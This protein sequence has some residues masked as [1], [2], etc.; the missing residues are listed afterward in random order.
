[1]IVRSALALEAWG[2]RP[3][4]PPPPIVLEKIGKHYDSDPSAAPAV[5][6]VSL[7]LR[8]GELTVL[9]GPSGSGKTTLLSIMGGILRPSTGRIVVCGRD[10]TTMTETQRSKVRIAHIG[11]VFQSYNL[12]PTLTAR[13]NIEIV[14]EVKGCAKRE[15]RERA[16]A[17]LA[18]VGLADKAG[19]YP[20]DLSG[21]QQQRVAVARALAGNSPIILADEPTAA[22]DS[23]NGR[24]IMEAFRALVTEQR[25]AVVIVSHD[26]RVIDLADRVIRIEDGRINEDIAMLQHLRAAGAGPGVLRRPRLIETRHG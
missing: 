13:Q 1:M 24:Q 12:F 21:G 5:S 8:A 16:L 14:L 25:R 10:I 26:S 7:T 18:D 20:A 3:K 2:V 9:I 6:G 15:R 22:L 17:L 19:A 23:A 4:D 11:F